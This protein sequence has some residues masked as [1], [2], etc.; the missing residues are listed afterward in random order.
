MDKALKLILALSLSI[1]AW[2]QS[3]LAPIF[4][5]QPAGGGGGATASIVQNPSKQCTGS[6]TT[7]VVTM[8][9]ATGSG[10][11]L[12][13]ANGGGITSARIQSINA[14]GTLV[15]SAGGCV[16]GGTSHAISTDCAW[17]L[18][19]TSG[20]SSITV[21][22]SGTLTGVQLVIY[23]LSCSGGTWSHDT[24]NAADDGT[25]TSPYTGVSLAGLTG[26]NDVLFQ[27]S[28]GFSVDPTAISGGYGNIISPNGI[29]FADLLN[30]TAG[31]TPNWTAA[32]NTGGR[33]SAGAAFKCQ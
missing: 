30:S 4:Q 26:T 1:P 19:S 33:T 6:F 32:G 20:V 27:W 25:S 8:T 13:I 15:V 31:S 16:N 11:L 23:E 29:T 14:G 17:V 5:K 10:N 12:F 3:I 18:S 28:D 24:E 9:Q 2:G 22:Y 7:C 21:T